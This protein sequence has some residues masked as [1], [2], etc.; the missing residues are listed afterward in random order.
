LKKKYFKS[1]SFV[2]RLILAAATLLFA[3]G[4]FTSNNRNWLLLYLISTI[5]LLT[6]YQRRPYHAMLWRITF[7]LVLAS[8][9]FMIYQL[10]DVFFVCECFTMRDNMRTALF[11]LLLF[12]AGLVVYGMAAH[13]MREESPI[14]RPIHRQH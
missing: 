11:F 9:G 3:T 6:I 13:V 2:Y 4:R 10:Y 1:F 14:R 5:I 7:C 8:A 12:I